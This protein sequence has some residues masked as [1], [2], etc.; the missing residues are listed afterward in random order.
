MEERQ[1]RERV[2]ACWDWWDGPVSGVVDYEGAPHL[3]ERRF[4]DEMDEWSNVYGLIPVTRDEFAWLMQRWQIWLDYEAAEDSE[5]GD[6]W[7]VLPQDAIRAEELD[8][9]LDALL[10]SATER[11][12]V[13]CLGYEL[14]RV[15]R[16]GVGSR[17]ASVYMLWR[18]NDVSRAPGRDVV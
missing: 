9:R 10:S 12:E 1:R 11:R 15:N 17:G 6:I 3:F 16:D 2:H 4:D 13:L 18:E 8:R 14:D 7:G 5:R